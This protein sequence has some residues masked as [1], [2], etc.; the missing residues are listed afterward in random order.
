PLPK[1]NIDTG[2]GFERAVRVVESVSGGRVVPSNF[3]T[4]LF[5]PL[6]EAIHAHVGQATR[7]GTPEGTR[8][9]RIADHVRAATFCISD[10]VRPSNL[11]QG[12]V[13]RK[14]LRRAMLDRHLLGGD[15]RSPWLHTLAEVVA[16]S[17]G[18]A[19]PE[20]REAR[21]LAASTIAAE[22]E[23]FAGAFLSGSQKLAVLA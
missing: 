17:L 15:L 14:V 8:V 4:A 18:G 16:R 6:L 7:F 21:A 20:L 13:V 5:A 11:K 10:G 12:Y 19:W 9:R 23:K 3:E 22:E 2:M 1:K